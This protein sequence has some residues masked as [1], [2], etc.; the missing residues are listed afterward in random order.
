MHVLIIEGDTELAAMLRR[1]LWREGHVVD[2]APS[3]RA[4]LQR[5]EGGG[6]DALILGATLPDTDGVAVTRRLR[7]DGIATP[8]L[9]LA[10]SATVND[11]LHGLD[12]GADDYLTAPFSYEELSARLRALAR[13]GDK[14]VLEDRLSIGDLILDRRTR[15]VTRGTLQLSL[16]PREFALLEY[17][18]RHAGQVITRAELLEQVWGYDFEPRAN[19]VDAAF[20]RLRK[21]VDAGRGRPL[22][23]T[24]RG[25]GYRIQNDA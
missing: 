16:A 25:I 23:L 7:N 3:G 15:I 18:M 8:I 17:L 19:A 20:K 10:T 11:R 22:I 2:V 13:R 12:A 1:R 5:A 9:M 14:P 4:G 6:Y 24:V 21:A